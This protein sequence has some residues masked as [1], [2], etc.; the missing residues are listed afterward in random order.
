MGYYQDLDEDRGWDEIIREDD[1]ERD[2]YA[3]QEAKSLQRKIDSAVNKALKKAK[4]LKPHS[5]I[6]RGEM[7]VVKCK[8]CK[9][10]FSARV[11]DRKRGWGKFCSK[12]CK[13]KKQEKRTHQYRKY[14][15]F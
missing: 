11:A 12:S 7:V 4:H 5:N 3:A 15:T 1:R 2:F 9:E 14:K 8:E 10:E 13:A 6:I